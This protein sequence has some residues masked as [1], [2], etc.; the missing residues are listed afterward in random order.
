MSWSLFPPQTKEVQLDEKWCFVG[1]KEKTIKGSGD[2]STTEG[3]V[4][5]HTAIDAESRLL[6]SLIP[7]KRTGENCDKLVEDVKKRTGDRTDVFYTSDEHAPYVKAIEKA[8][9]T[10]VRARKKQSSGKT[11]KPLLRMPPNLCYA[12]VKKTRKNGRMVK[13]DRTL[14]FGT[15]V[16][17]SL[18]LIASLVSKKINTAFVE[19][20]N[21]TDRGKN[22]RKRRKTYCFSKDLKIHNAASY[23]VA[24][25]YNFLWPI[26]TLALKNSDGKNI[27]RTP[28]MAAGLTDHIWS[29][30]EWCTYPVYP[31][32]I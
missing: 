24:Y 21:G 19:R 22:S 4:W 20:H 7:G 32:L 26:R 2:Q 6:V 17:L 11:T 14:V 9:G 16:L 8:Y 28:G 27:Q 1:K 31:L 12:T 13:V 18:Y 3:D 5:D 25:G 15:F 10:P 30:K 29:L 23:F